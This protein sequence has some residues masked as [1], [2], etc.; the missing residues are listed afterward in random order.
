MSTNVPT[1]MGRT[2]TYTS[3]RKF[4]LEKI[5]VVHSYSGPDFISSCLFNFIQML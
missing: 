4:S 2:S 5:Q 3:H 1:E